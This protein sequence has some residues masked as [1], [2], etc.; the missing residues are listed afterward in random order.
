LG[1]LAGCATPGTSGKPTVV[2]SFYPLQYVAE[3][4]VGTHAEITNLT[5]PGVEP[6]DLE[7]SPR[8]TADLSSA[9]VVFYE[10]GLAPAVDEAISND[11]PERVEGGLDPHF[12]LD[13]SLLAETVTAFSTAMQKADPKYAADY[14]SN[15]AGVQKDLLALD[16]EI[17]AGLASCRI[18]TLV[19]SH[20][21]FEYF[22]RRYGF[23]VNP[24]AGLSPDAEPSARRLSDL[25]ALVRSKGVTTVFSERLASPRV[26]ETLA[27]EAGVTTEVLDPLEGLA[28][29]SSGDYLSVM[30]HN[31]QVLRA[32]QECT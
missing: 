14:R 9:S 21:A 30:R 15:A 3:R 4:V 20:D 17:K 18:R 11:A 8:Q 23:T 22:G 7:L 31:L 32:A 24:I 19:V 6:H 26:A 5:K 27:S 16:A 12:W 1:T 28:K 2:A 29:G 25:A 13:P 10:K